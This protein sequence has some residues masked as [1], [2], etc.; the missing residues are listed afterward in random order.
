MEQSVAIDITYR[1][2]SSDETTHRR[3]DPHRIFSKDGHV[4]L[5]AWCHRAEGDRIFRL[6]RIVD[7]ELSDEAQRSEPGE[8]SSAPAFFGGP[9]LRSVR[10]R[11]DPSARW[12]L[13]ASHT[14]DVVAAEDGTIEAVLPVAGDPWLA[15]LL[16]RAGDGVAVLA[17]FDADG[18]EIDIDAAIEPRREL[19]RQTLARYG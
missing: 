3:I 13:T 4:Y 2:A 9:P 11:V 6:D 19:A 7:A 14:T 17:H 16:L 10:V 12:I 8:D 18:N 15:R 5:A 1:A